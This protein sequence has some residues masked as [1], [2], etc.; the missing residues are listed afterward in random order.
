MPGSFEGNR[1]DPALVGG[2]QKFNKG[3][4]TG[5]GMYPK[6]PVRPMNYI[7]ATRA[8]LNANLRSLI[9]RLKRGV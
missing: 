9:L 2:V 4:G 1:P 7:Q 3:D 6:T 5:F 8:R